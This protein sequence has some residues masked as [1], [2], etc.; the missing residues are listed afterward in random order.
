MWIVHE[1]EVK[2]VPDEEV[3]ESE[4]SP[5]LMAKYFTRKATGRTP[6]KWVYVYFG[7]TAEEAKAGVN[8]YWLKK[9]ADAEAEIVKIKG[10]IIP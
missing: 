10:N 9:L 5:P 3:A 1:R 4:F 2:R 6:A 8:S 7:E